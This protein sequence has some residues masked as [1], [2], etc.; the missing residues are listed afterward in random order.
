LEILE[1][2]QKQVR[3][4]FYTKQIKYQAFAISKT[5]HNQSHHRDD[6]GWV[7]VEPGRCLLAELHQHQ[8]WGRIVIMK[9]KLLH[10]VEK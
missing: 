8:E 9:W 3:E 7:F 2:F 6:V 4:R 10:L 1:I 5:I